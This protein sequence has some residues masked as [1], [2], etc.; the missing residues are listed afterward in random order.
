MKSRRFIDHL[1]ESYGCEAVPNTTTSL[2]GMLRRKESKSAVVSCGSKSA[3][4]IVSVAG[5]N[6]TYLQGCMAA[7]CHEGTHARQQMPC[8]S[9]ASPARASRLSGIVILSSLAVLRLMMTRT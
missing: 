7:E 2:N 8:Y 9:A 5:V 6:P 3:Q 1:V 4:A